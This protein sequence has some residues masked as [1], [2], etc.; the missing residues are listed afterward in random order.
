[1]KGALGH[2]KPSAHCNKKQPYS[3]S[4]KKA[5]PAFPKAVGKAWA[6]HKPGLG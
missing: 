5:M 4:K 2:K 6:W 3:K 1:M